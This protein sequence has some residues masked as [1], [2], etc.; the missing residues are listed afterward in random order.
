MDYAQ[1]FFHTQPAPP[2][3]NNAC[4]VTGGTVGGLPTYNNPCLISGYT[5]HQP[6]YFTFDLSLGYNTGD[7]PAN[8]YLRNVSIQ[9]VV[10]NITDRDS[11]YSYK[12][13]TGG[14]LPCACDVFQ[15]L[16]GRMIS[17]RLQKTF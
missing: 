11:P 6:S 10:Q 12:I 17:M 2:N 8:E 14:G 3:V 16:F 13:T 1:H 7:R 9:I 5:N 15:S 4:I